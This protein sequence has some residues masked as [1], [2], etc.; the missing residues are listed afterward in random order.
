MNSLLLDLSVALRFFARRRA[1]TAVIVLTMALALGANTA[2]FSVLRAFVFSSL[3]FPEPERVV[4]VWTVR[5]IDGRGPVNFLDAY[6]NVKLIRE[7]TRFWEHLGIA[8]ATDFNWQVDGGDARRLQGAR[9]DLEFFRAMR[10][11][12][13]LGRVFTAGEM[14]PNAAPVALISERLWLSAFSGDRSVLGRSVRLNGVPH[15]IVGVLPAPFAE[16]LGTELWTPLDLPPPMWTNIVGARALTVF[17]RLAPGVTVDAAREELRAFAPRAIEAHPDNRNWSWTVQPRREALLNGAD[18]A[19]L[20]VQAGAG[21]LLL[22]AIT[23]LAS[24]LLAWAAERQRETAVRLALGASGWR[25]ARQFLVQS[26]VLVAAGGLAGAGLAAVALPLLQR[27]NPNPT[28]AAFLAG[29]R[30]D[31][32]ALGFAAA[33]VLG[34]GLVAGLLPAWQSRRTSFNEALRSESRGASLGRAGLRWQQ[35]M[36]VVQAAVAVLIL[37]GAGLAAVGFSRLARVPL[38]V[39]LEQRA[40]FQIQ[41]PE[42]AYATHE[43]RARFVRELEQNLAREPQL[44]AFAFTGSLPVG[45]GQWGGG[46][47]PQRASGEFDR[48]PTVL[49]FRRVTPGYFAALGM[50]LLEG[51]RLE[52]RDT[53]AAP[54]VAVVSRSTAEKFWPGATAIGRKLRRVGQPDAPLVEVVGVVGNV[55]DA[56]AASPEADA[57]YMPWE[58]VSMRRG[59]V[60]LSGAA[61]AE[62]IA[63]GRRALAATAPEV[64]AYNPGALEDFA[65]QGTA[66]PRLQMALLGVFAVIAVGI[67]ALGSYG[68]MSQLVANR[69]KEMAIRAALGATRGEVLGLVLWTNARLALLGAL[70]GLAAAV[71][72]ARWARSALSGFPADALWPYAAV[73]VGVLALTQVASW[74]PARRAAALDVQKVLAGA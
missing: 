51:R 31:G 29:L 10:V 54:N 73:V 17:A 19:L 38:G 67:T 61:P 24:L 37:T 7:T 5:E 18:R 68:V 47:I 1:A 6:V 26:L 62:L 27:L 56:G 49:H 8:F 20:F 35:A 46:F 44:R 2:A 32:G 12:P 14:G 13:A 25:L 72:A 22:L 39:Q 33:L 52:A 28:F 40:A 60:V 55:R 21:V 9:A 30:L 69:E 48:D 74:L 34:T 36:V 11:Q 53:G 50:T 66:L 42:P 59:W 41:F 43:A 15:T 63:A 45:D 58:Q 23:N 70:L 64:A 57:I 4:N 16:P 65:W 71:L 3:G